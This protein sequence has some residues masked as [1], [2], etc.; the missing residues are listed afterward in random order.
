MRT[1]SELLRNRASGALGAL[2]RFSVR[3][4]AHEFGN[5]AEQFTCGHAGGENVGAV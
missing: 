5:A 1:A 2:C 3:L 4:Y